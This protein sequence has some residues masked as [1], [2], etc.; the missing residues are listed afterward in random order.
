MGSVTAD[1][2][3]QR[4]RARGID[5]A[6]LLE[7]LERVPVATA[8][9]LSD[10]EREVLASLGVDPE[11]SSTVPVAAGLARRAQLEAQCV[12]V[13]EVAERLGR[14]PSRVRQRLAGPNRSLLGWHRQAGKREWVLPGFQFDYGLVE[15]PE[16][17]ALLRALP[18][19]S[20]TSPVAL[21]EWL[22]APQAHLDG[23]SRVRILLEDGQLEQLLAEAET[24]AM[25]P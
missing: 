9:R 10:D 24:F 17:W 1:E 12:S 18:S 21:V 2:F 20:E 8:A 3:E 13:V 6:E 25:L 15:L 22:T 14:D 16:W 11:A 7:A 5:P 4:T 19:A 23:R